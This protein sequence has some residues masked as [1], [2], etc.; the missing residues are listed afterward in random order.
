[1]LRI[2]L[3]G[4][5]ADTDRDELELEQPPPFVE[6]GGERYEPVLSHYDEHLRDVAG[7]W[8]YRLMSPYRAMPRGYEAPRVK[9]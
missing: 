4:G 7:R 9:P 1:M 8:R 5:R 2:I 6:R 3:E